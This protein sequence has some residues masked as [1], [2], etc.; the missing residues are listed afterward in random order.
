MNSINSLMLQ[1]DLSFFHEGRFS[2]LD[3]MKWM[4]SNTRFIMN[5]S[6]YSFEEFLSIEP[7]GKIDIIIREKQLCPKSIFNYCIFET[8]EE[9]SCLPVSRLMYIKNLVKF[10]L[11]NNK[12]SGHF[13][14]EDFLTML[15][16][17][18]R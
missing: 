16:T 12:C 15:H 5:D 18:Y 9:L 6:E 13:S 11:E 3:I 7:D 1:P 10:G 17:E 2:R 14:F 4:S 8:N